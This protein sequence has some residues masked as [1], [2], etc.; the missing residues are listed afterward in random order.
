MQSANLKNADR[1][2]QI[3]KQITNRESQNENHKSKSLHI[4]MAE[5][6]N[7]NASAVSQ[8]RCKNSLTA[9]R[10]ETASQWRVAKLR[11]IPRTVCLMYG[12]RAGGSQGGSKKGG[13]WVGGRVGGRSFLLPALGMRACSPSLSAASSNINVLTNTGHHRSPSTGKPALLIK[14][15]RGLGCK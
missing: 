7:A 9:L 8:K 1:K 3:P 13:W 15:P 14:A 2:K 12:R 4:I 5:T 11:Q 6:E 10:P